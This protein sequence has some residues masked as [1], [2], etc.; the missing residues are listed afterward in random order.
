LIAGLEENTQVRDMLIS[1]HPMGRLG[2]SDE[3]AE[4][5]IWLSSEKA[6]FVTGAYYAVDGGYLA[7]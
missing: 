1:L 4:L 2:E 5:V 3:V 6:S 7:K